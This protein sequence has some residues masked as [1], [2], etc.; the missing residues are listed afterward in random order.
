M[1]ELHSV[2]VVFVSLNEGIDC[3]SPAGKLQL[4][5]L[6]SL[7]EFERERI[8]ERVMAGLRRARAQGKQL[9]RPKRVVSAARVLTV[10]GLGVDAAALSLGVSRSTLK[11]WRK[12]VRQSLSV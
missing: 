10:E 12:E 1:E 5:I 7:T 11:R 9:G 3:T 6:A 8:R 2:G 4:H